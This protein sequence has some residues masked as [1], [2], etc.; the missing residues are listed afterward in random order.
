MSFTY[1]FLASPVGELKLVANG[2]RLVAIL[3]ENDKPNRVRLGPMSEA[4][5]NPIL[6]RTAQQLKEYFAG[7]RDCFELELDFAGTDFQKKVW[8]ALLT[9]PFGETRS[10]S[11]IA[12][13]IG[14]PGAVRAVGAANGKNPISIVAPCHRVIG[15]SGKLTGFAG[16]LEAK[17]LLLT[18][19]GGQQGE[20]G[21]LEGF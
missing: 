14:N 8:A 16:G 10:Y 11:Q 5:E 7:T 17:A 18:L 1:T 21:R 6:V 12:E 20:T 19:E 4:P 3:W 2:S 9:I 13:Q 15:A